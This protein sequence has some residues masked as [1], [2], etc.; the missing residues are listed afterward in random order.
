[1][2]LFMSVGNLIHRKGHEIVKYIQ[3]EKGN[4]YLFDLEADPGETTDL[5]NKQVKIFT[6]MKEKYIAWETSMLKPI[7]LNVD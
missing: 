5:K 3:D 1:M 7:P 6:R 2:E 4:E